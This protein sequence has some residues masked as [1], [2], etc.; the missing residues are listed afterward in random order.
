M[1]DLHG[2]AVDGQVFVNLSGLGLLALSPHQA[3]LLSAR[4]LRY[5]TEAEM[6]AKP[7][8]TRQAVGLA[9]TEWHAKR[10]QRLLEL[11]GGLER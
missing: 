11:R 9:S 2:G 7:L 1:T 10:R 4:L 3:R 6:Q 5:A 8:T